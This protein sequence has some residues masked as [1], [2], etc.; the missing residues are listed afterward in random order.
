VLV[1]A[2]AARLVDTT[3]IFS[4]KGFTTPRYIFPH[5]N[6]LYYTV[7]CPTFVSFALIHGGN[8]MDCIWLAHERNDTGTHISASY[9]LTQIA[10]G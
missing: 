3:V 6:W 1:L 9:K 7:P 10:F 5:V 4:S 2:E 8:I